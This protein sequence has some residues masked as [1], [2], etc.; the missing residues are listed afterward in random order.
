MKTP[1]AVLNDHYHML[2]S[3][4]WPLPVGYRERAGM[5]V[6]RVACAV[7]AKLRLPLC[8]AAVLLR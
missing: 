6:A 7:L 5:C 8:R 1:V 3:P 2:R 4:N